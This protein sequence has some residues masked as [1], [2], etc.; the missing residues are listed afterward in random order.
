MPR[1]PARRT[2]AVVVV[3]AAAA[4]IATGTLAV[5]TAMRP[6]G[7]P[8]AGEAT[9]DAP[10][11]TPSAEP[12]AIDWQIDKRR[13][14]ALR[15]D[16]AYVEKVA[17]ASDTVSSD[18]TGLR[19][20]PAEAAEF[21]RQ[22]TLPAKLEE[23]RAILAPLG[24]SGGVWVEN[25]V[26]EP[27][28]MV[29]AIVGEVGPDVR[30]RIAEIAGADPLR[31]TT[32]ERTEQQLMD[33]GAALDATPAGRAG[34]LTGWGVDITRDRVSVSVDPAAPASVEADLVASSGDVFSFTRQG[35]ATVGTG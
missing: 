10:T 34:W 8:A 14:F 26:A 28:V 9:A 27:Q 21:A 35:P 22:E 2:R 29:V 17:A 24:A 5:A 3:V 15:S 6:E 1:T 12:D 32:A 33:I 31:V 30:E 23:M 7:R 25:P 13:I 4:V 18:W 16:R 20:T 11:A 19:L